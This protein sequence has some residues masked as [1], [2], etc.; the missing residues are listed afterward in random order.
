MSAST[1]SQSKVW[2]IT[3]ASRGFGTLFVRNALQRGDR[4]IATARNPQSLIETFGDQPN[5][6][7]VKVDVT[8]E[9][10]AVE[11]VRQGVERFG[12]IDI[13]VNNA[14]Y[15]VLGAVEETSI[16]EAKANFDTN[17]FGLLAVSRAVLPQMRK[18]RSGHVVNISSLGGYSAYH[19]W[20]VYGASKFAVE[21]LTEAMSQELA[22]LGIHATVVEPGFFRTDFLHDNSL[23]ST[24]TEIAD[25]A[26][27]VGK[28][29]VF[30]AGA[31]HQQPG[32]P[33]KLAAAILKLV[34]SDNPPVRL[35]LGTD[36]IARIEQKH[37]F[38]EG[39]LAA[40]RDLAVSTDHDDVV[41]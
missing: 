30:A 15:G 29:R 18:Q 36:A 21:G 23:V 22:P 2:F 33:E 28:M 5:L 9:A 13:L 7:A 37:K 26:D 31:N 4:V 3:G 27:T 12:R 10:D 20:G 35:P 41:R 11:A 14:G 39:E 6:L 19:G 38:V 32:N 40:W 16:A 25:Y 24:K 8:N 34:D 1:Q 17:V